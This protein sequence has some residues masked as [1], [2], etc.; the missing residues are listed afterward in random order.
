MSQRRPQSARRAE[1]V[2]PSHEAKRRVGPLHE[3][4]TEHERATYLDTEVCRRFLIEPRRWRNDPEFGRV[5]EL[6]P[7]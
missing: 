1:T 3:P 4:L 6:G 5:L 7:A 2:A